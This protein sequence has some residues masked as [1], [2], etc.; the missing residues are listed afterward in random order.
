MKVE[1][2]VKYNI[3]EEF[4]EKLKSEEKIS[5]LYPPQADIIRKNLLKEKNLVVSMPTAGG[6]TLI[7]AL[8][9]LKKFNERKCKAVYI[10][11]LVALLVPP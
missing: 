7:A 11:P 3:P 4:V 5:D 1:E 10:A 9:M 8:A 2:L 6:K